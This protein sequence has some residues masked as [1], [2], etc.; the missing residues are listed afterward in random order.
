MWHERSIFARF[1]PTLEMVPCHGV[2]KQTKK[3]RPRNNYFFS[4]P[5]IRLRAHPQKATTLST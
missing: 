5:S 4:P 1:S 2:A 3:E